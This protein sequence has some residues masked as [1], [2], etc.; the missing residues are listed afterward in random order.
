MGIDLAKN[1]F[2]AC[3]VNE[4]MKP[5][6][7]KRLKRNEQEVNMP[8]IIKSLQRLGLSAE[9]WLTLSTEFE[10][11]FCYAAGAELMMNAYKA[12][13][14]HKRLRGMGRARALLNR[15]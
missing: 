4:H 12:H 2:Q 1:V 6:F 7:N 9:Q 14:H 10:K 15:A 13:T 8:P 11:H 3:G 5:Q